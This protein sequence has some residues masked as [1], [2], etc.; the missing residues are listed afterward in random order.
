MVNPSNFQLSVFSVPFRLIG[1][2]FDQCKNKMQIFNLCLFHRLYRG[3]EVVVGSEDP[4]QNFLKG[5]FV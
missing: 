3:S 4:L 5:I 2:H 1:L